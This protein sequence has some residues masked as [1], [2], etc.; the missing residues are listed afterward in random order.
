MNK[1][2]RL[3]ANYRRHVSVPWQRTMAGA[4]RVMIVVCAKERERAL[5]YQLD[6]FKEATRNAGHD[7]MLADAT[8]WF[9]EWMAE[10]D[11]REAY[12][13]DDLS[14]LT[15][16][17]QLAAIREARAEIGGGRRAAGHLCEDSTRHP[18][19]RCCRGA[20]GGGTREEAYRGGPEGGGDCEMKLFTE[21]QMISSATVSEIDVEAFESFMR[22][23][24]KQTE[25]DPQSETDDD[26]CDASVCAELDG[27]LRPTLYGLIVFGRGPQRYRRGR[28]WLLMRRGRRE[29]NG[30]EPEL[31]NEVEG[32]YVRVMIRTR[33]GTGPGGGPGPETVS[34]R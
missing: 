23:Q 27:V 15:G 19:R 32:G 16:N 14:H 17:E 34:T 22:A 2:S 28:G 20:L 30:T 12:F 18:V 10:D 11:Y 25:D 13:V 7:W 29:F 4:Q 9:A 1:I 6:E 26:L 5:R 3:A 33:A 21:H 31:I 8:R 24:R